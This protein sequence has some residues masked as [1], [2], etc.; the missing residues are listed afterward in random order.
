MSD[1]ITRVENTTGEYITSRLVLLVHLIGV[2]CEYCLNSNVETLGI[3]SLEKY[4]SR[5]LSVFRRVHRRFCDNKGCFIRIASQII[6]NALVPELFHEC[7]I[8]DDTTLHW[9]WL[10]LLVECFISDTKIQLFIVVLAHLCAILRNGT[11]VC[12]LC[13][14]LKQEGH[15]SILLYH[16][17]LRS[18]L[19]YHRWVHS[20]LPIPSW[21]ICQFSLKKG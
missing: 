5:I 20:C 19:E 4:L 15:S 10:N 6:K 13:V 7:P 16:C 9:V 1:T 14:K 21:W 18:Q 8:C 3:K 12:I 2:E 11:I 17:Y